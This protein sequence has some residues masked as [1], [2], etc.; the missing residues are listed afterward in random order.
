MGGPGCRRLA[1]SRVI[2]CK[3]PQVAARARSPLAVQRNRGYARI[4]DRDAHGRTDLGKGGDNVIA[5]LGS[6]GPAG[7]TEDDAVS[8]VRRL[9]SGSMQRTWGRCVSTG[10]ADTR[11][12]SY[13]RPASSRQGPLPWQGA[14]TPREPWRQ[15]E[16]TTRG[17][18]LF[19]VGPRAPLQ[20]C[21]WKLN[22]TGR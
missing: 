13:C 12:P 4:D 7:R 22:C 21:Q 14:Q 15:G 6:C 20:A 16:R 19:R 3:Q 2:C 9:M 17:E 10:S 11:R 8:R 5:G 18:P 1:G